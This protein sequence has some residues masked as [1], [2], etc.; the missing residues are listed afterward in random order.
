MARSIE[1]TIRAEGV[2]DNDAAGLKRVAGY[3]GNS[4]LGSRKR[5]Y[6]SEQL[7]EYI[8]VETDDVVKTIDL[9]DSD[10]PLVLFLIKEEANIH[11]YALVSEQIEA[12]FLAGDIAQRNLQNNRMLWSPGS[13]PD[14]FGF[15]VTDSCAS[16]GHC[17][18]K[19]PPARR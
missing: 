2:S 9:S 3:L 5:L 1:D 12:R 7:N 4:N 10:S 17:S 18:R 11:H 15:G 13:G 6:L 16:I 8:E 14:E 19:D